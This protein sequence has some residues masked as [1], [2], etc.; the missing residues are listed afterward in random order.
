[1]CRV[2]TNYVGMVYGLDISYFQMRQLAWITEMKTSAHTPLGCLKA[3]GL[4]ESL[5]I[6]ILAAAN[7]QW[8][9]SKVIRKN[10]IALRFFYVVG[11]LTL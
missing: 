4:S 8:L 2:L 1:M 11:G 10:Y 5:T 7:K 3:H 6:P 9:T